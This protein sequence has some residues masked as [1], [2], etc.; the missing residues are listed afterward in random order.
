MQSLQSLVPHPPARTS[1]T[2]SASWCGRPV[3]RVPISFWR[4]H[5]DEEMRAQNFTS[6]N[7]IAHIQNF[8]ASLGGPIWRDRAWFWASWVQQDIRLV[9]S[10]GNLV[11]RTLLKTSNVKGNWQATKDDM[12][13]VLWFLGSKE[14]S[15][16]GTGNAQVEPESARWFQGN[17]FPEG[18]PH[19]LLKF[20]DD[21]VMSS[22]NFLS[23]KY[24]Y[25]GTG[26]TLE[27]VGGLAGFG[28]PLARDGRGG[29]EAR[30]AGG[31]GRVG[32][33]GRQDRAGRD[34]GVG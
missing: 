23:V 32:V 20:Q 18:R 7:G 30:V 8:N 5:P 1:R 25:Y 14:K 10:A 4:H 33:G 34:S 9:R 21:R 15:N 24:A 6:A 27:P 28:L 29:R 31:Q 22:N 19:G 11:D 12:I 3:D 26:F 2:Y 13:S 16:R 17:A